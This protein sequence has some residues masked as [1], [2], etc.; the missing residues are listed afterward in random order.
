MLP[1][2]LVSNLNRAAERVQSFKQ[3]ALDQSQSYR[4]N[5]DVGEMTEQ[6]LSHMGRQL[7]KRGIALK[8]RLEPALDLDSFPGPFALIA[9]H[10]PNGRG[11]GPRST[12]F[13][14]GIDTRTNGAV[15]AP[16]RPACRL[17]G[18]N[19]PFRAC[20]HNWPKGQC[21]LGGVDTYRI[22]KMMAARVTTAR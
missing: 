20:G 4:R 8:L 10:L 13:L 12:S 9:P 11:H 15:Q 19:E 6:V 1:F 21:T 5:F 22:H 18:P 17:C 14:T 3:V 7:R 2:N 16:G